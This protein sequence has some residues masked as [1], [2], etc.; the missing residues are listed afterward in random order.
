MTCVVVS[1]SPFSSCVYLIFKAGQ[2]DCNYTVARLGGCQR[3]VEVAT[4]TGTLLPYV[5]TQTMGWG[6]TDDVPSTFQVKLHQLDVSS[7]CIKPY[8]G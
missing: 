8:E 3:S 7:C 2:L 1:C 6:R 4:A 5:A